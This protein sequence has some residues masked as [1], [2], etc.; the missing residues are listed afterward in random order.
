MVRRQAALTIHEVSVT[1]YCPISSDSPFDSAAEYSRR[2]RPGLTNLNAERPRSTRASP[3]AHPRAAATPVAAAA[4]FTP[5]P[6]AA[7]KSQSSATLATLATRPIA[8]ASIG[9][10]SAR[11]NTDSDI[12]SIMKK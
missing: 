10:P 9:L 12:L 6:S 11:A 2:P 4:P 3:A 8:R 7:T 1:E 5:S